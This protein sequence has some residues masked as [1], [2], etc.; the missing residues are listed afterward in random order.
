MGEFARMLRKF[1]RSAR[2]WGGHRR[3][4]VRAAPRPGR[5]LH[6]GELDPRPAGDLPQHGGRHPRPADFLDAAE[7]FEARPDAAAMDDLEKAW[8]LEPL[9]V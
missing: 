3:H 4:L 9:F 2:I 8:N 7:A 5:H 6:R 1:S